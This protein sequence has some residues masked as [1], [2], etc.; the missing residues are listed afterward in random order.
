MGK[1]DRIDS[2]RKEIEDGTQ[3]WLHARV[4][5]AN[6][7]MPGQPD[8]Q[9]S[10][11]DYGRIFTVLGRFAATGAR[12][13]D[14]AATIISS[15]S[16][17]LGRRQL[18][19]KL[20]Q[21]MVPLATGDWYDVR[22]ATGPE[23]PRRSD[24]MRPPTYRWNLRLEVLWQELTGWSRST[25][26]ERVSIGWALAAILREDGVDARYAP[27]AAKAVREEA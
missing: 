24:C 9:V 27:L 26:G 16:P 15:I 21:V 3:A 10:V 25:D 18:E 19:A 12:E 22:L 20:A 13:A 1:A 2:L 14:A 4:T 8:W 5:K 6:E 7:Y 17:S 23:A 11:E